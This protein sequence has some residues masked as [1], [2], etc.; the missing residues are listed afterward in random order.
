ML[1]NLQHILLTN[2]V[3][4]ICIDNINLHT[5][6]INVLLYVNFLDRKLQHD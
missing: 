3:T 1:L 2:Y 6:I 5:I 4:I